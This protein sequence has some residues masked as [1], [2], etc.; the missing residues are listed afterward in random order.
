MNVARRSGSAG[1]PS[2]RM[3]YPRARRA[4]AALPLDRIQLLH[5]SRSAAP[6]G[7]AARAFHF[8][9]STEFADGHTNGWPSQTTF[10]RSGAE[11][12]KERGAARLSRKTQGKNQCSASPQMGDRPEI[13]RAKHR[14][15]SQEEVLVA[16]SVRNFIAG[17][18]AHAGAARRPMRDMP[19]QIQ[20][21]IVRRSLSPQANR[22]R[23]ALSALQPWSRIFQ[24][25]PDPTPARGGLFVG[26]RGEGRRTRRAAQGGAWRAGHDPQT[27]CA[28]VAAA[29]PPDL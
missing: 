27:D 21:H 18:Q 20:A 10:V 3:S 2:S 1:L 14:Y 5:R 13:S 17:L 16:K 4:S 15:A 8:A 7:P 12:T 26:L 25:R 22:A 23:V 11:K 24:R 29:A 19:A 9:R 28:I 6:S